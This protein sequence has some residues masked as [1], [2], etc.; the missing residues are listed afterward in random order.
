VPSAGSR[1]LDDLG[2]HVE[3]HG[4]YFLHTLSFRV[5]NGDQMLDELRD[6]ATALAVRPTAEP[7]ARAAKT[8]T[9]PARAEAD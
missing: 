3:H 7:S 9:T 8:S 6:L 2:E 5:R 1:L 4:V